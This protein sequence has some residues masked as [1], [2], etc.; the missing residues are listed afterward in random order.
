MHEL[1][2]LE[3]RLKMLVGNAEYRR[4]RIT[5]IRR[6]K[7][8]IKMDLKKFSGIVWTGLQWMKIW[9]IGWIF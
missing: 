6:L 7:D 9:I 1:Q 8:N 2:R 5:Y 4:P 3:V